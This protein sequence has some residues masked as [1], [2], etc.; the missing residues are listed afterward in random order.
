MRRRQFLKT[1]A[2]GPLAASVSPLMSAADS[3][4][5]TKRTRPAKK[6]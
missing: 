5:P 2:A 3:K 1:I 4:K 6:K